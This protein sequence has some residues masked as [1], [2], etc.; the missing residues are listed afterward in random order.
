MSN[1]ISNSIECLPAGYEYLQSACLR[2]KPTDKPFATLDSNVKKIVSPTHFAWPGLTLT[3][4]ARDTSVASNPNPIVIETNISNPNV[5]FDFTPGQIDLS[6]N[7]DIY[8]EKGFAVIPLKFTDDVGNQ[9]LTLTER[10]IKL[11]VQTTDTTP[12]VYAPD[13]S[14]LIG[15]LIGTVID[16]R[17]A[18]VLG[19]ST[20]A[21]QD[22][23]GKEA[24]IQIPLDMLFEGGNISTT[25]IIDKISMRIGMPVGAKVK[26]YEPKIYAAESFYCPNVETICLPCITSFK[27]TFEPQIEDV[28]RTCDKSI[29]AQNGYD[30]KISAEVTTEG[31]QPETLRRLFGSVPLKGGY[32]KAEIITATVPVNLKVSNAALNTTIENIAVKVD[33]GTCVKSFK[34]IANVNPLPGQVAL[35]NNGT[36]NGLLFNSADVGKPYTIETTVLDPDRQRVQV[37]KSVTLIGDLIGDIGKSGTD[38]SPAK[39]IYKDFSLSLSSFDVLTQSENKLSSMTIRVT[40][41]TNSNFEFDLPK[42]C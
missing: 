41:L 29:V 1:T 28:V 6:E 24:K 39:L 11:A 26:L 38:S 40:S 19:D 4:S 8:T 42:V 16:P 21:T 15:S 33:E 37:K 34:V 27:P 13:T 2:I 30:M 5:G 23:R 20:A 25:K 32:G 17:L 12:I 36:Q 14:Q 18:V 3:K 9:A 22:M 35:T 31:F 10:T 7:F